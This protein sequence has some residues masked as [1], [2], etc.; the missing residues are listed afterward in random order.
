MWL[1]LLA[2]ALLSGLL[3]CVLPLSAGCVAAG[4]LWTE[5]NGVGIPPQ[6]LPDF[7][8]LA[9]KLS[10]A[11]VNISA[12]QSTKDSGSQNSLSEDESDP[13]DRFDQPFEQYELAHPRSLGSGFIINR[14]G[15]ILTNAHVIEGAQH[16]RVTLKDGRQ[17]T[18]R[19]IGRDTKN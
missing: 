10:P 9:A 1:K 4:P 14:A 2:I 16:I 17:F 19:L 8:A 5:F 6:T 12:E 3:A 18:A 7:V 13:F 11:V 15:Y